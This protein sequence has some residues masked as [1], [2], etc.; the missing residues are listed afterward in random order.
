MLLWTNQA[1][2]SSLQSPNLPISPPDA[3]L[4]L[5]LFAQRCANCHGALGQGD[6]ELA[7]N[8]PN[9]PAN[10]ADP[11]WRKTAVPTDLFNTISNGRAQNGMPPFG[12]ASSNPLSEADRWHLVATIYSLGTTAAAI[13]QGEELY[14]ANC[15]AC[16]GGAGNEVATADLTN[17]DYWF[18]Q[19]NEAAFTTLTSP[20]IA[21][22]SYDLSEADLWLIT[23]YARTF[24]YFFSDP[25]A[26]V[27]PIP[28]ATI[29]GTVF[30][31]S[32]NEIQSDGEVLLRAFT[33]DFQEQLSLT[34]AVDA[35]G[36]Y[37]FDLTDVAPDWIYLISVDYND[38]LFT[39]AADQ[40]RR[41]QPT[42]DMPV[43][44]Y[45]K[46]SEATAVNIDQVHLIF[47]FGEEV[48]DVSELYV[49]NNV[50]TAVFVG[51]TGNPDDG[52][53]EFALPAGA[54]AVNFR[55]SF[56]NINSFTAAP[57]IIATDSGWAD[58]LPLQ[59]G[60][61]A[62]T[63][64]VSYQLP[65]R[66]GLTIAHPLPYRTNNITAIVPEVGVRLD[67]A[68]WTMQ[69]S[70]E[71][72]G[73]IYTS[74]TH[75]PTTEGEALALQLNGRPNLVTDSSGNIIPIRN[76]TRE[77][78]IGSSALLI[79]L[80]AAAYTVRTWQ[81]PALPS[82]RAELLQTLAQLDDAYEAH[83]ITPRQYEHQREQLKAK[84]ITL[85]QETV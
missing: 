19:S 66:D 30:N 38:L 42:L 1:P 26:P 77:L 58:T 32:T 5:D 49:L 69:G 24:S 3:S 45:E 12:S 51:E 82:S 33:A 54:Q 72:P 8:L 9:P 10:F 27:S 56:G 17:L 46:S 68:A 73:G 83:Q 59:P 15:A 34:A 52:T 14:T 63:V 35:D 36:R 41:A 47:G 16:H 39:S 78:I 28:A 71:L 65:Y 6:G 48:V 76:Q 53:V 62:M 75:L 4:G 61:N 18:N 74:Y 22:H 60:S 23:D 44:V 25:T 7:P 40:I 20:T 79:A 64:L 29:N 57:E 84:L 55:R 70:E 11:E 31:G 21:E 81:K 13:S 85:W 37:Q 43:I 67:G 2:V 80:A 50:G